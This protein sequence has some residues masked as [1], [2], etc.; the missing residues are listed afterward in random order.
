MNNWVDG[1]SWLHNAYL[2][3]ATV[4]LIIAAIGFSV[5]GDYGV[6]WDESLEIGMV[7]NNFDLIVKGKPLPTDLKHYGVLFNL[8]AEVVFQA[9][10]FA[11]KGLDYDPLADSRVDVSNDQATFQDIIYKG[12]RDRI[13]V[14][15]PF[16]F[17]VSLIAYIAVAGLVGILVGKQYAWFAPI[18]MALFP[19]FWGHSFFNPK[20]SPFAAMFTLGTLASAYLVAY[21]LDQEN[22]NK[23]QLGL[24]RITLYS[25]LYGILIGLVTSTRIGGFF[26][27]FFFGLTHLLIRLFQGNLLAYIRRFL[28]FYILI[29]LAWAITTT[30]F[31]PASWSNPVVW[32]IDT[33]QY[34]SAH[35]RDAGDFFE[36]R[37]WTSQDLPWYYL[38]RWLSI[39]IPVIFQVSFWAG[40]G[41]II[42]KYKHFSYLQKA[43]TIL[44][45]LQ[46]FFIPFVAIIR[47]STIYGGMRQFL[48]VLP[49]VA[50]IA[51]AAL[52]WIY[53]LLKPKFLQWFAVG[54]IAVWLS[55]IAADMAA[56]HPY[57]YTYFNRA[58]GGLANAGKYYDTDYWGTS[59]SEGMKWLNQNGEANSTV[60]VGGS[61]HSARIYA[62][63]DNFTLYE[64]DNPEQPLT[65]N[66]D[67]YLVLHRWDL[68]EKYPECPIIH[69]IERQGIPL[70][71]IK[72]CR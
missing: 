30:A 25:L 1:K 12:L 64:M 56:L 62:D 31:H 65:G 58:V 61:F 14:K 32:F 54:L 38:P 26:L 19:R 37:N 7:K 27:L 51:S 48:F 70:T 44:V 52:I 46:V 33:L 66:P 59:L 4:I 71:S 39:S 53:Q 43:G 11:Q 22:Q 18:V 5:V 36:G 42:Y 13:Q 35:V 21:Y 8:S 6:S 47:D 69:T 3:V 9:T 2:K 49:G 40:L 60:L 16:T 57:E 50:V 72:Q 23:T 10:Q 68:P 29:G 24:N 67:Y 55:L 20:D 28:P 41:L 45:L 17:F 15:H 34:L 63:S